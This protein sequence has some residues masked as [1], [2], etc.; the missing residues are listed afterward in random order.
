MTPFEISVPEGSAPV[1]SRP[2][3][4]NTILSKEVAATLNQHL[5]AGLTPHS[6]APYSSALVVIKSGGVRFT[7]SYKKRSKISKL[8]QLP[9]PRMDQVLDC[10]GSGRMVSLF[11]WVFSFHQ[12]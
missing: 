12:I 5:A 10:M 6:T 2:H 8:S 3:R 7:M 4:I 11:D 9:I 1:T